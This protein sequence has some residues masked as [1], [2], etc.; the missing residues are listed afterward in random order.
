MTNNIKNTL[1]EVKSIVNDLK[2]QAEKGTA[3]DATEKANLERRINHVLDK[4]NP[5]HTNL[6]ADLETDLKALENIESIVGAEKIR[7]EAEKKA[8]EEKNSKLTADLQTKDNLLK[9]KDEEIGNKITKDLI[10]K[11]ETV[12]NKN[13]ELKKVEKKNPDGTPMKDKDG[14]IIYEEV[15]DLSELKTALSEIKG[16]TDFSKIDTSIGEVKDKVNKISPNGTNYWSIGAGV[17][18]GLSFLLI[19]YSTFFK[20]NNK[21]LKD[22]HEE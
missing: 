11:L 13:L 9:Q 6:A 3:W 19:C 21:V 5:R 18:A 8:L 17:L 14:N 22:I 10:T 16:K 2:V 12:A 1:D 7:I 15:V 4:T 20:P